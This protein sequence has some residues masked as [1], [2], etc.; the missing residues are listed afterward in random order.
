WL[1]YAPSSQAS[2]VWLGRALAPVQIAEVIKTTLT[3]LLSGQ[4]FAAALRTAQGDILWS[5]LPDNTTVSAIEPLRSI[6]GW[7]IVFS[8]P[9]RHGWGA[10]RAWLWYGF[11]LL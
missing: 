4:P 6:S 11:I 5:N 8:H 9:V 2:D 10:Q 3:P 7:E 1:F